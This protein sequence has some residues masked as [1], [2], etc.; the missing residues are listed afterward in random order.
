M[1]APPL[2]L[3]LVM[4]GIEASYRWCEAL[5]RQQAGNF[6]HA[7]RLLPF[8][9]RRA[10]CALYAFMRVTDDLADEPGEVALQRARLTAWRQQLDDCTG[11]PLFP[12][13]RHT[14]ERYGIPRRYLTDVIDGVEM[15]LYVDR[16][17]TFPELYGYCYRVASAVGLCCVHIWGHDGAEALQHAE[18]AGIALQLTNI[19][20]DVAEDAGRGRLYL[21]QEDLATFGV[22]ETEVMTGQMSGHLRE[23]L[24][25]QARRAYTYYEAA[26]PLERQ[27]PP[28]GRAVFSVIWGTYRGLLDRIVASDY[29]VYS[30]RL[31]VSRWRNS[32]WCY[33]RCRSAGGGCNVGRVEERGPPI[34]ET[35]AQRHR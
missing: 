18:A 13:F 20:R 16:Y 22:S 21:P 17:A 24:A 31:S 8:A 23:L 29:D 35:G 10:M 19:L 26:R 4:P 11:H 12:A 14:I 15:D 30:R 1:S 7:F 32:G 3:P 5:A 9:Q 2:G 34:D 27:L 33:E 28:A 6:Y 25:F